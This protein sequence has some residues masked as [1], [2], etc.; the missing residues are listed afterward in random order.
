[1][2]S[3]GTS[4]LEQLVAQ[5][6]AQG[7]QTAVVAIED[8]YDEFSYGIADPQAIRDFLAYTL[9]ELEPPAS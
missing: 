6:Q 7:L 5:R 3:G 4:R 2:P 1:M 8:V 9:G